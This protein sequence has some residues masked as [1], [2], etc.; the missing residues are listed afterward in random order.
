[1]TVLLKWPNYNQLAKCS[2]SVHTKPGLVEISAKPKNLSF[3]GK[4]K[5]IKESRAKSLRNLASQFAIYVGAVNNILK[6][7]R[8]YENLGDPL[9]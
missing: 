3:A 8:R 2:H 6:R 9:G 7:K 5:L 1:M 4:L